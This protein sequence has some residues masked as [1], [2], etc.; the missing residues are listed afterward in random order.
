MLEL[1]HIGHSAK[2]RGIDGAFKTRIEDHYIP[3]LLKAKAV[4]INLNGSKVP[5][6]IESAEDKGH[7]LIKLD[8]VDSPEAASA[9][10]S[11]ELYL[12]KT[13]VEDSAINQKEE[14][15][16]L[17]GYSLYNQ[18]NELISTIDEIVEYPNQILAKFN[19][20][21][22]EVLIPVHED[23]IIELKPDQQRLQLEIAEGLLTLN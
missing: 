22:S 5:F 9:L 4:F 1:I 16:E 14:S 2:S 15:H 20:Q 13:E 12:D 19:Y 21:G 11:K 17:V 3:S 8:E 7:I 23:L 6:L 18:E 10:L